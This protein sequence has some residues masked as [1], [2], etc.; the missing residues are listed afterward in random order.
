[1]VDPEDRRLGEGAEQDPVELSCGVGVVPERLLD[2]D[3]GAA[4]LVGPGELLHDQLE[5]RG[6]D[7]R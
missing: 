3:A 2:D 5:H 7:G 1:V 6:R 4:R